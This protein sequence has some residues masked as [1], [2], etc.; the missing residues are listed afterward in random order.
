MNDPGKD[1]RNVF[2]GCD[3]LKYV[4][5]Y[6]DYNDKEFCGM[7]IKKDDSIVSSAPSKNS[8]GLLTTVALLMIILQAYF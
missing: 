7:K 6:S 3:E 8:I 5:V 2:S 4:Y 1:S